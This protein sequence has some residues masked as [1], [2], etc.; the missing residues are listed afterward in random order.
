MAT[1]AISLKLDEALKQKI[2]QKAEDNGISMS[3]FISLVLTNA[4]ENFSVNMDKP[5]PN[6][7]KTTTPLMV[8]EPRSTYGINRAHAAD[9]I[10]ERS[11]ALQST[12]HVFKTAEEFAAFYDATYG[13]Y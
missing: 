7:K 9:V 13:D 1:T 11:Q 8:A 10:L 3:A 6:V 2:Q 5:S 12:A 4:V